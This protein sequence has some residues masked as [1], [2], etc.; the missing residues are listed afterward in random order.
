MTNKDVYKNWAPAGKKWVDWVRP[1]PFIFI[2]NKLKKY[3][4]LNL[5]LPYFKGL[6]KPDASTALIVDL[7]DY[8]SVEAGIEL[9]KLGYRP[10]PIYNGVIEPDGAKCTTDNRSILPALVWGASILSDITIPDDAPPAF[11]TDSNRLDRFRE[12]LSVFDNSWDIYPQDIPSENYFLKEGID[13]I[14]IIC[15]G[16]KIPRDFKEIF[17]DFPKKQMPIFLTDGSIEPRCIKK[18]K[19]NNPK[20]RRKS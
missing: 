18:G 17:D 5:S 3:V 7:P 15:K 9:A 19:K 11:L 1:V 13:K 6:E 14:L 16:N 20:E 10:I 2:N 8:E 12:D 4:P